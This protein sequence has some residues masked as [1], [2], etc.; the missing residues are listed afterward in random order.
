MA[1]ETLHEKSVTARATPFAGSAARLA[2][3]ARL[4]TKK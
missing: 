3:G 1:F 2:K 4:R